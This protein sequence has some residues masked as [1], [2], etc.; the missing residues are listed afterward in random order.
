MPL[1][2]EQFFDLQQSFKQALRF[3]HKAMG[4]IYEI[5]INHDDSVYAEQATEAAFQEIDRLE[6]VL[7]RFIDNIEK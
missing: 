1:Q 3:S 7:S 4:T 2:I 6:Q 5:Y